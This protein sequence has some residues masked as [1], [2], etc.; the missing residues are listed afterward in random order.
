MSPEPKIRILIV[1]DDPSIVRLLGRFVGDLSFEAVPAIHPREALRLAS[2]QEI[3]IALVDLHMPEMEGLELMEL[4]QRLH[5]DMEVILMTGD[6]SIESAVEAI[7]SGAYDY[8][9]KPINF[10]HLTQALNAIRDQ[11]LRRIER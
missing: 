10:R 11:V 2:Q 7:K 9:P 4:L 8:L 5:D 3:H 6:Y 1:D